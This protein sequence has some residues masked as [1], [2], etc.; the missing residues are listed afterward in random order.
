MV[1]G[2]PA[3][4]TQRAKP[5]QQLIVWLGQILAVSKR[6]DE[7]AALNVR[8]MVISVDSLHSHLAWK[9]K[10]EMS[11]GHGMEFPIIADGERKVA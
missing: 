10:I 2:E 3:H 11:L 1:V 6:Y 5:V 7:F 4:R 9:S 8:P